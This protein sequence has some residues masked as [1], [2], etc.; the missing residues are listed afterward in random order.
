MIGSSARGYSIMNEA[1]L[2]AQ[3]GTALRKLWFRTYTNIDMTRCDVC[4]NEKWPKG[5]F[6]DM[7]FWDW[8]GPAGFIEFK[9]F[10]PPTHGG[11]ARTSFSLSKI[12]PEQRAWFL[13]AQEENAYHLYIGLGTVHGTAGAKKEPRL[14][15]VVPWAYWQAIEKELL[16][17][18]KSL[19]LTIRSG[20]RKKI[21]YQGLVAT[22]L[23]SGYGL[24]WA[25][26]GWQFPQGHPI[27]QSRPH[28]LYAG[29]RSLKAMRARQ[30]ELREEQR[31]QWGTKG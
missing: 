5:G 9:V 22:K 23:L 28:G 27:Y 21:Q 3:I 8:K 12:S 15:W 25:K 31:R 7:M 2:R 10:P 18:Q 16:P 1:K 20:L 11:W 30:S 13:F 4:G 26:G 17:I 14:A 29:A 19:P 24:E 6:P